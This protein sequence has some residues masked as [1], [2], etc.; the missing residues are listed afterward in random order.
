ME[1]NDYDKEIIVHHC[2]PV[3]ELRLHLAAFTQYDTKLKD[4]KDFEYEG[5]QVYFFNNTYYNN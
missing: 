1:L 3:K 5:K 4:C 2:K